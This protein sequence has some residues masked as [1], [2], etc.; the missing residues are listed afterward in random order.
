MA[1]PN[2]VIQEFPLTFEKGLVTEIEESTL[3]LGQAAALLNWEP[4]AQGGLR[5]RNRWQNISKAGLPT[6]YQVRG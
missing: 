3:D 5:A 1:T 4:T 2:P 6:D